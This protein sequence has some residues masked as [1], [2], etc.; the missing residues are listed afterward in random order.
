MSAIYASA[1]SLQLLHLTPPEERQLD[2]N[3]LIDQYQQILLA[4]TGKKSTE[5]SVIVEGTLYC[6]HYLIDAYRRNH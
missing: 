6:K 1:K 5:L 3:V 4:L 2:I